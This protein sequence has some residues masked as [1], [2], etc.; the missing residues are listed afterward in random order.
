MGFYLDIV[1]LSK[2]P[3]EFREVPPPA[4]FWVLYL[5]SVFALAC[6]G[7]AAKQ[8][9]GGL[10]HEDS[11]IDKLLIGSFGLAL[12]GLLVTGI[13]FIGM[14]KFIKCEQEELSHGF[15][16]F[17]FPFFRNRLKRSNVLRIDLVNKRP[18]ANLAPQLHDDSQYYVQ[19][20]WRVVAAL[21]GGREKVLDKHVEKEALVPLSSTL[22]EWL[23]QSPST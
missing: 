11:L 22:N 12:L 9:L 21:R 16:L 17:G 23:A 3:T 6:M 20:H 19:G 10:A 14:R 4:Y 7:L 1:P 15:L 2:K 13:K 5:I 8:V 18:A